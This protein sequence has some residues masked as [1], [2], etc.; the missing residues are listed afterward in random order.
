MSVPL[1]PP[2]GELTTKSVPLEVAW[3]TV[4]DVSSSFTLLDILNLFAKFLDLRLD[5]Q[6]R[7]L[8][9]EVRRFRKGRVRFTIELLQKEIE[10]LSRFAR[11]IEGFLKLRQV[12]A[13]ADH[14]LTHVTAIREVCDFL[15]Q[16]DRIHFHHL[17]AAI[18]QFADP[19]L[20]TQAIS[21]GETRG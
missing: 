12:T 7:L 16:P 8:D 14:F 10:H 20:Q 9:H 18:Q 21:I 11:S 1:P 13:Q 19:F 15:G 3:L 5:G 6:A 4:R 17:T 2:D